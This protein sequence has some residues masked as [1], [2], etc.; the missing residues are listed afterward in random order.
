STGGGRAVTVGR[1]A[2]RYRIPEGALAKVLQ[3]L[4]RGGIALGTRGVGGGY[5]LAKNPSQITVLQ[6]LNVFEPPRPSDQCLLAEMGEP[7]CSDRTACALRSLFD[8]VDEVVRCT[9]AS[10]TL[11]TLAGGKSVPHT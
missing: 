6:I 5:R 7:D 3:Q 11:E 8:E 4:V 2:E 10:V 1:V 9:F